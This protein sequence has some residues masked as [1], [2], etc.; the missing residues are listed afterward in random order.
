MNRVY[1]SQKELDDMVQ[2]A[3]ILSLKSN[4]Q[5]VGLYKTAILLSQITVFYNLLEGLV[6]VFLGLEDETLSL[7]GFGIDSFVEV[8]SGIGIWHMV[9]RMKR[10]LAG[11]VD[12]FERTA[13]QITGGAFYLLAL[14]LIFTAVVNLY[15]GHRPE[16][17]FW[18]IVISLV[19]I[20]TMGFLIS[21]KMRVGKQL[22]SD[23][24]IADASCTK[25]CLY[26]SFVLLLASAGYAI[27]GIGGLDSLGAVAISVFAFREGRE[28]FEKARGKNCSC[29][30]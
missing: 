11:D 20:V 28:A 16:T 3:K 14:G 8:I 4:G 22:Q 6:S 1:G 23:A 9:Y 7:L 27:T 21:F 29:H 17:T 15:H 25:T 13:L 12:P 19:S 30:G 18:G 24:I 5:R 10:D 2:D 26:L